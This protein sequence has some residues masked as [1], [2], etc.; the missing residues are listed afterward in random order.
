M[1]VRLLAIKGNFTVC[2]KR[3]RSIFHP[4]SICYSIADIDECSRHDGH[5][6]A[7][8]AR[9]ENTRGSFN[10]VCRHGFRLDVESSACI[11][12]SPD[13]L[14]HHVLRSI[15]PTYL[16]YT[17]SSPNEYICTW[18]AATGSVTVISVQLN[19]YPSLYLPVAYKHR[20][21]GIFNVRWCPIHFS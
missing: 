15:F 11:G 8:N 4:M 14:Q 19:V 1:Q 13:R 5:V 6:C 12:E 9:C 16:L 10:C 7:M 20:P 2:V 17:M 21:R 3:P 18:R